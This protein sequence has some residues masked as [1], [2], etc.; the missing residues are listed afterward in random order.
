MRRAVT[1][2]LFLQGELHPLYAELTPLVQESVSGWAGR[3]AGADGKGRT[4]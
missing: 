2:E 3:G 4:A 1:K